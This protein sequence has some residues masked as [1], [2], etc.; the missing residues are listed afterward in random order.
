MRIADSS[1]ETGNFTFNSAVIGLD[2]A[3]GVVDGGL[4]QRGDNSICLD[5]RIKI[6]I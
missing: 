2:A 6:Q 4:K 3:Q 5:N 1:I